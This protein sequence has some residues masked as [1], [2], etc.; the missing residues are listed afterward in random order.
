ML[1][2]G[3]PV[4]EDEPMEAQLDLESCPI[5][6]ARYG[7]ERRGAFVSGEDAQLLPLRAI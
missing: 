3:S 7:D 6:A 5:C 1:L 4:G 2:I